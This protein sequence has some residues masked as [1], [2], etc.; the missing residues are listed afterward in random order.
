MKQVAQKKNSSALLKRSY[1]CL[2]ALLVS[3][4]FSRNNLPYCLNS[5]VVFSGKGGSWHREPCT[6]LRAGVSQASS[7][8]PFASANIRDVFEYL[9]VKQFVRKSGKT[10]TSS[11]ANR[12]SLIELRQRLTNNRALACRSMLFLKRIGWMPAS[13]CFACLQPR[14]KIV[15]KKIQLEQIYLFSGIS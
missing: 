7:V 12:R 6:A 9:H 11:T 5:V 15:H 4:G 10:L 2:L 8:P 1:R 14:L 13:G 3:F